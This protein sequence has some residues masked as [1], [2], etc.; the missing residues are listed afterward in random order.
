VKN[1]V[2]V[3]GEIM[4]PGLFQYEVSITLLEAII[5]AGGPSFY[6]KANDVFVIRGDETKPEALRINIK[7]IYEKGDFRQNIALQNNDIVYVP[8]NLPGDIRDMVRSVY[9][10]LAVMRLPMDVYGASALPRTEGFPL[11]REAAP[12]PSTVISTPQLPQT[13]GGAWGAQ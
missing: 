2:F 8:T 6:G 7:D 5:R 12:T 9:P 4:R 13:E 10:F 11:L 3:F 1:K